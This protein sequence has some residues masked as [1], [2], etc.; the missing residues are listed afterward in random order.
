MEQII[1]NVLDMQSIAFL[2]CF[3]DDFIHTKNEM[4]LVGI[5]AIKSLVMYEKRDII[6]W[7]A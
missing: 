6:L 4:L 2:G 7:K 3:K 1:I 5:K